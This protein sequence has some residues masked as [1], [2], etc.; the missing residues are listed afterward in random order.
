[1]TNKPTYEALEQRLRELEQAQRERNKVDVELRESQSKL[2]EAQKLAGLGY[3]T[4]DIA[5]G[6]VVWSEVVY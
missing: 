6:K 3:W 4:W 1:M 5:T 2:Q